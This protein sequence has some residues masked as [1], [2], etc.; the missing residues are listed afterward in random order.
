MSETELR[1]KFT[2]CALE[3]IDASSAAKA[4]DYIGNLESLTD[5]R[6]LC[7]LIRG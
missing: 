5:I 6:P 2:E 4:L 7:D 3:A 1:A